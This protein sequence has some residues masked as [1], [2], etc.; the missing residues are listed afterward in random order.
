MLATHAC[1]CSTSPKCTFVC[2][3]AAF[4]HIVFVTS[5]VVMTYPHTQ[6]GVYQAIITTTN[7]VAQ[8]G[9]FI[10]YITQSV[11]EFGS[12]LADTLT[13][14]GGYQANSGTPADDAL[15][16][17]ITGGTGR[18]LGATGEMI[19]RDSAS[20]QRLGLLRVYVPKL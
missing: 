12:K 4:H 14:I 3:L 15:Y 20:G 19:F 10:S 7:A 16:L 1:I 5:S 8:P 9:A 6:V 18:F 2:K 11:F 17:A 13:L